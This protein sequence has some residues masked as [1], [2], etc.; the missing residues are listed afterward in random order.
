MR[1]TDIRLEERDGGGWCLSGLVRFDAR[2]RA[3]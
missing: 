2:E 1:A 3:Q